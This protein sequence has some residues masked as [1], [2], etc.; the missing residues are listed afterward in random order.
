MCALMRLRKLLV[1]SPDNI[2]LGY[3]N[4]IQSLSDLT[5]EALI[6]LFN[7]L[8]NYRDA[9]IDRFV[10]TAV[11][12]V[13]AAS[14]ETAATTAAFQSSINA[15]RGVDV[16]TVLLDQDVI[17]DPRGVQSE[18]VYRRTGK[19]I[20]RALSE[21]KNLTA[22]VKAGENRLKSLVKTDLQLV[23]TK[24]SDLSLTNSG[25][26]FYRRVL[27]GRENCALCVIASTQRYFVG[28]LMPIHPA[29]DC[30]VDAVD[31]NWDP[32][33]VIDPETLET[34]HGQVEEFAGIA[35]RNG[36]D[37]D[38]RQLLIS[39]ENSE[40]GPVLSWRSGYDQ[41]LSVAPMLT[42]G[43][44]FVSQFDSTSL[45]QTYGRTDLF[46]YIGDGAE[47][48]FE[49]AD[50][51]ETY[52]GNGY[53]NI[54][55]YLRDLY[56][57]D[58][59]GG[60]RSQMRFQAQSNVAT[61][62]GLMRRSAINTEGEV[63]RTTSWN[64]FGDPSFSE[65][66]ASDPE[67]LIGMTYFA[68]AFQSTST[69]FEIAERFAAMRVAKGNAARSGNIIITIQLKPGDR[70]LDIESLNNLNRFAMNFD[71]GEEEILLDR[72]LQFRVVDYRPEDDDN[73]TDRML[74]EIFEGG[75]NR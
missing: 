24:Q 21:G 43:E 61:L 12:I 22:A 27:T 2:L 49:E 65:L 67:G 13:R 23:K 14:R 44:P 33:Q 26:R 55:G 66:A 20:Y 72:G 39:N 1:P 51:L 5:A 46:D 62:D 59:S 18:S 50:A 9:N 8:P 19:S 53:S 31:A 52:T 3:I 29:C 4:R 45:K 15:E 32:G 75:E 73:P 35:A 38:Y 7:N 57:D 25:F 58:P 69:N 48:T 71:L 64:A 28:N 70:G 60:S 56:S 68:P 37:V 6:V 11:P 17:D 47:L 42:G 36:R 34:T 10:S 16:P 41:S 30:V 63:Y 40:L 74:V 54:N